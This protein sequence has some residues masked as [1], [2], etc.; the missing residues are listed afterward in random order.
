MQQNTAGEKVGLEMVNSVMAGRLEAKSNMNVILRLCD[1]I[2]ACVTNKTVI[3]YYFQ[4]QYSQIDW[5]RKEN[6]RIPAVYSFINIFFKRL[7][8][9]VL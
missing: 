9:N 2:R 7:K 6:S 5:K 3:T 1:S 4:I 8:Q